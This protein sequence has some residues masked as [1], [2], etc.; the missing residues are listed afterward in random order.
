MKRLRVP[1]GPSSVTGVRPADSRIGMLSRA[2]FIA[3]HTMFAVPTDTCTIAACAR[4]VT[5]AWPW[6]IATA[7]FSCGQISGR[8]MWELSAPARP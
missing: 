2:A 1:C 4:P 8:G 5:S 7:R 3:P 6:A